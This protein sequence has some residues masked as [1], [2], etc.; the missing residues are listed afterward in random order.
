MFCTSTRSS[1]ER[2]VFLLSLSSYSL[3]G[4]GFP[5]P[6][7]RKACLN[8]LITIISLPE[9]RFPSAPVS[10][11]APAPHITRCYHKKFRYIVL[12]PPL[13]TFDLQD[14]LSLSLLSNP[15][16]A[17]ALFPLRLFSTLYFS[18]PWI[19]SGATA[20]HLPYHLS[21]PQLRARGVLSHSIRMVPTACHTQL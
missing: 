1:T 20:L 9:T 21:M 7:P 13:S 5:L 11:A 16:S 4:S 6:G 18:N 2:R 14:L 15:G 10:L 12:E 17:P 8:L 3:L 19:C